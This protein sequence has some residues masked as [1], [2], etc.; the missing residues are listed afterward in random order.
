M[1]AHNDPRADDPWAAD[2]CLFGEPCCTPSPA[3]PALRLIALKALGSAAL[4]TGIVGAVVPLLPTTPFI[5]VSAWAF[6]RSSP[7]LEGWLADHQTFGPLLQGW[8]A[9]RAIPRPAKA[10]AAMSLPLGLAGLWLTGAHPAV[11]AAAAAC[12]AAVGGWI[13]TRPS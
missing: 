1:P 6:A 2:L 7:R 3:S 11:L 10:A 8:R 13:L 4:A 9:R 12:I 5:L